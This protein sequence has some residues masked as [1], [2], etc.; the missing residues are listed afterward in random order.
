M[1]SPLG[2]VI[3][4]KRISI[5][6]RDNTLIVGCRGVTYDDIFVENVIGDSEEEKVDFDSSKIV[7]DPNSVASEFGIIELNALFQTILRVSYLAATQVIEIVGSKGSRSI[8]EFVD[9]YKR[10]AEKHSILEVSLFPLHNNL[11]LII[12]IF[13]YSFVFVFYS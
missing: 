13:N 7:V 6:D 4:L 1:S 2:L 9:A 5:K 3:K 12:Y 8:A 10:E 11:L